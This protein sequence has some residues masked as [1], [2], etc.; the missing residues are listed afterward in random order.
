[1]TMTDT[2]TA[3]VNTAS[4][5]T[6]LNLSDYDFDLPPERVAKYPLP[7]RDQSRMLVVHR[8][9]GLIE[10]RQ[11]CHLPEYLQPGDLVIVNNTKVSPVR[12]R[13][14]R[15]GFTGKVEILLLHPDADNPLQWAALMKPTRR[16]PPGTIVEFPGTE[17]TLE[18]V[19]IEEKVRG[20][21]KFHLKEFPTVSAL[22]D[23]I[24]EMPIP[25]YLNRPVE[26]QDKV[27]YQTVYSKEHTVMPGSQA[28]P[29]A[30]LHFTPEVLQTLVENGIQVKEVTLAVSTGTFR[31]VHSDDIRQHEM[32]P[33]LYTI[34]QDVVDAIRETKANG[35]RVIAIGT[36]VTKT[37]E[38]SA[39]NHGGAP[40]AESDWS[41]LFIYPGFKFNVVNALITNFH[42][43]KTTLLM[44][45]SA[46]SDRELMLR[47]YHEAIAQEY[48]F[49]S[50]GDCMLIV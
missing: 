19:A 25:P 7:E 47:A 5:P 23:A 40:V 6:G 31:S 15:R 20:W 26:A 22:M 21:A 12:L 28:A 32:D 46:F 11:F 41:R 4:L 39:F 10:H 35:R 2:N 17:S 37:L 36:T 50:Y 3:T 14:N 44:L 49:F 42:L 48:R 29:T 38:T 16:L 43:P 30:G 8:D 45:I 1:M 34:P 24:G 13:G 18:V 9:T 27:T 33:E